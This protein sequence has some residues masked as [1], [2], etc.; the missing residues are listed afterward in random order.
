MIL[1]RFEAADGAAILSWI[2]NEREFRMWSADRFGNYP[3]APEII[4]AHHEMC[5]RSGSFFPLTAVNEDGSVVGHLI[6]RYT[7]DTKDDVRFGFVIVDS[8]RRGTG[9]GRKM[10][11]LAKTYAVDVLH[12][13]RMSLGVFEDN[14]AARKCYEAVGFSEINIGEELYHVLG[15]TWRCIEMELILP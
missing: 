3:S 4:A 12:A 15:E 8:S 9:L 13:K 11:E 6:L 14:G 2:K 5:S 1:R 10:L 7:D